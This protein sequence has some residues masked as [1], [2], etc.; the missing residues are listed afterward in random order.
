[1]PRSK[2]R[3]QALKHALDSCTE[4]D[5][6]FNGM[7]RKMHHTGDIYSRDTISQ[8]LQPWRGPVNARR[9]YRKK[10]KW[11]QRNI[12]ND[13]S[14]IDAG[15]AL[16]SVYAATVTSLPAGNGSLEGFSSNELPVDFNTDQV[17]ETTYGKVVL[18]PREA[19]LRFAHDVC[20]DTMPQC[21]RLWV[22]G[23][24]VG[25]WAASAA[26]C[27]Y[28]AKG[29]PTWT[30]TTRTPQRTK[31]FDANESEL[32]ELSAIGLALETALQMKED[33]VR[34][35]KVLIFSDSRHALHDLV[36]PERAISSTVRQSLARHVLERAEDITAAGMTVETHWVPGHAG[37][38][39]NKKAHNAAKRA[40]RNSGAYP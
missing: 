1:M 5:I 19:A 30:E 29:T 36:K 18:R 16:I 17:W 33:G 7:I 13:S 6:A 11:L 12:G 21:A 4:A 14:D 24:C 28:K 32:S 22:D 23:S 9:A 20:S 15:R 25:S 40:A 35:D 2:R 34:L 38:I 37:M 10:L 26:V 8:K 3:N 27:K 31:C 39:G